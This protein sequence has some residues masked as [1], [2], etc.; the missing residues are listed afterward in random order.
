MLQGQFSNCKNLI[1]HSE[2]KGWERKKVWI[3]QGRPGAIRWGASCCCWWL[4]C[5]TTTKTCVH[6][7]DQSNN[8]K[9]PNASTNYQSAHQKK[10][11]N[12]HRIPI[13]NIHPSTQSIS[14]FSQTT[15]FL[16][17][18]EIPKEVNPTPSHNASKP[19]KIS[20]THSSIPECLKNL[21]HEDSPNS[22]KASKIPGPLSST[23]SQC[24]LFTKLCNMSLTSHTSGQYSEIVSKLWSLWVM[25]SNI[26]NL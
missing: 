12:S 5:S 1:Y 21:Q 19:N 16:E 26:R 7:I 20:S 2:A 9:Q 18:L 25:I 3:L 22:P 11:I 10:R 4:R 24:L 6:L 8:P 23:D 13:S 17:F 14:A 15:Q